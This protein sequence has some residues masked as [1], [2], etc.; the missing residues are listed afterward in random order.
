MEGL[1]VLYNIFS[2][3][4]IT[5]PPVVLPPM[6]IPE[7]GDIIVVKPLMLTLAYLLGKRYTQDSSKPPTTEIDLRKAYASNI[8]I[9]C[10]MN[11]P[12]GRNL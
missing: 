1:V 9:I 12:T 3:G 10:D 6:P 7:I 4:V 2:T 11:D 5:L 8:A